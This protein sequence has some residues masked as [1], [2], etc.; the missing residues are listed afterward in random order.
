MNRLSRDL[1]PVHSVHSATRWV[2]STRAC[3]LADEAAGPQTADEVAC[4]RVGH[5]CNVHGQAQDD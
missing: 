2:L 4:K 1:F 3:A 5:I